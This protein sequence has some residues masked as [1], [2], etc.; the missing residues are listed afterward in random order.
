MKRLLIS[1]A[2]LI[3]LCGLSTKAVAGQAFKLEFLNSISADQRFLD[4]GY[5]LIL[6]HKPVSKTQEKFWNRQIERFIAKDAQCQII[7][8][9]NIQAEDNIY[10]DG[11]SYE[12]AKKES[13]DTDL[14]TVADTPSETA[15]SG[16]VS[17]AITMIGVMIDNGFYLK[18][19]ISVIITVIFLILAICCLIIFYKVIIIAYRILFPMILKIRSRLS[20]VTKSPY[21]TVSRRDATIK[22]PD[23]TK[24]AD[25]TVNQTSPQSEAK[26]SVI[27]DSSLP[28]DLLFVAG[29]IF[30]RNENSQT[31]T[32]PYCQAENL[33]KNNLK[34]HLFE[35]CSKM[36]EGDKAEL[37]RYLNVVIAGQNN[38][39]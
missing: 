9:Y 1:L 33:K 14:M 25:K 21:K 18:D 7:K 15:T 26:N 37:S 38:I 24:S 29:T 6:T 22:H 30:K 12:Y 19:I 10:T 8:D 16:F 17:T 23:V 35:R 27:P 34:R 28:Q 13:D 3:A 31:Y 5:I 4:D 36:T 11:W 39:A 32:C 20:K 2:L